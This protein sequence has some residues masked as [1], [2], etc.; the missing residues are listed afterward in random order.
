[1]IHATSTQLPCVHV[2]RT[3]TAGDISRAG[4][5]AAPDCPSEWHW[6]LARLGIVIAP[7]DFTLTRRAVLAATSARLLR[8]H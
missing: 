2:P 5:T 4:V 7:R 8:D 6:G 1:M 3:W